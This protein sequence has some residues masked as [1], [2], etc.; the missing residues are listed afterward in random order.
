L[1]TGS[2]GTKHRSVRHA[3]SAST[4][5]SGED[6]DEELDMIGVI[7]QFVDELVL[8]LLLDSS[9]EAEP[10]LDIDDGRNAVEGM[11]HEESEGA[12]P[13]P[14]DEEVSEERVPN[15]CPSNSRREFSQRRRGEIRGIARLCECPSMHVSARFVPPPLRSHLAAGHCVNG[16][17]QRLQIRLENDWRTSALFTRNLSRNWT[18]SGFF[19]TPKTPE[20]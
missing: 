6:A 12:A 14:L 1:G 4:A 2:R 3:K 15:R 10:Q 5:K 19:T 18:E 17:S 9:V 13:F 8:K 20:F 16:K 11:D 7:E